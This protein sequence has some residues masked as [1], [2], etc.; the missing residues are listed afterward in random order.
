MGHSRLAGVSAPSFG[1]AG[2]RARFWVQN[3]PQKHAMYDMRN[4]G[5]DTVAVRWYD[6]NIQRSIKG[7]N[8]RAIIG[9]SAVDPRAPILILGSP[10]SSRIGRELIDEV[11][12]IVQIVLPPISGE[13]PIVTHWKVKIR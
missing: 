7:A 10:C 9:I 5:L 8:S 1:R 13:R 6:A 12:V 3:D 11:D 2:T 4:Y